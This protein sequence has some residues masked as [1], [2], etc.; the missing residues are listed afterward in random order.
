MYADFYV[1]KCATNEWMMLFTDIIADIIIASML[2]DLRIFDI[3]RFEIKSKNSKM[4]LC[5]NIVHTHTYFHYEY[6]YG[7]SYLLFSLTMFL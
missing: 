5:D 3:V 6:R 2:N 1:R 4:F 7:T